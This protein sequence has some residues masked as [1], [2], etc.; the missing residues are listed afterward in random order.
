M[1]CYIYGVIEGKKNKGFI[2][3][4]MEGK[5]VS[6]L[7]RRDLGA[8]VSESPLTIYEQNEK[9]LLTHLQVLEE[10]MKGYNVIPM[11]FSTVAR[12]EEEIEKL[13]ERGYPI[14]KESLKRIEKKREF[15]LE[16]RLDKGFFKE[17]EKIEDIKRAKERIVSLDSQASLEDRIRVGK[18][19]AIEVAKRRRDYLE[20][21]EKVLKKASLKSTP[22]IKK[23]EGVIANTA[24]LVERDKEAEFEKSIYSLGERYEGRLRF[25]YAG[26]LPPYSFTGIEIRVVS[27][28]ILDEARK[29]LGLGEEGSL[30]EVKKA[31]RN[32]SLRYHPDRSKE[33]KEK[34]EERFKRIAHSY[35]LLYSYCRNSPSLGYSLKKEEEKVPIVMESGVG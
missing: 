34:A 20:D 32:L 10:V 3:S 30:K 33:E 35:Q 22:L 18:M 27:L 25:K 2:S 26:P 17:I 13:L 15:D 1:G 11:R 24:F 23:D 31:Y 29:E 28:K 12:T 5:K 4:G 7:S 16:I 14:F 8:V 21:I 6:I 9:N 19:V